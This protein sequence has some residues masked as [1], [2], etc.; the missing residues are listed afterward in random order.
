MYKLTP[1]TAA[2]G[3]FTARARPGADQTPESSKVGSSAKLVACVQ[4]STNVTNGIPISFK[5][6]TLA[7]EGVL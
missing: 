1:R 2:D 5:V 7:G 4:G 6:L 3:T